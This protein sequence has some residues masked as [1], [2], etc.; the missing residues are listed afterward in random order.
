[1]AFVRAVSV[2]FAGVAAVGVAHAQT[3]FT[4]SDQQVEEVFGL[5]DARLDLMEPVAAW[6]YAHKLPILDEARERQVL[7]AS[8][9]RAEAMGVASDGARQLMSLQMQ[10]A[11]AVQERLITQWTRAGAVLTPPQDLRTQ[12]RPQLDDIG[13]RLWRAIYLGLPEFER[14]DF[15]AAYA[16]QAARISAPGVAASDVK[17]LVAA[18]QRLRS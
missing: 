4:E 15:G 8:V 10:L 16:A 9:R 6:K 11:R 17:A 3:A 7:D 14:E 2:M 13:R 18:L 12:L 1:M 5:M